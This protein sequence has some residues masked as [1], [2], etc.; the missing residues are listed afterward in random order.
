LEY[1]A[2]L[3]KFQMPPTKHVV[4]G[5]YATYEL[6]DSILEKILDAFEERSLLD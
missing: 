5:R 4:K 3:N 1:F 2:L 6:C